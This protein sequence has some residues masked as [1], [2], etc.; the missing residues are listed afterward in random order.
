MP[1][2]KEYDEAFPCALP[3]LVF[4]I[5]SSSPEIASTRPVLKHLKFL[6]EG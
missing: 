3:A 6:Y 5:E 1:A 4:K 2:A